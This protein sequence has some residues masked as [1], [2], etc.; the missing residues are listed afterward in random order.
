VAETPK[1]NQTMIFE[2][3]NFHILTGGPGAGKTTVL[4]ALRRRGF[5]GVDEAARQILREQKAVGG[6]ATHDGDRVKYRD[7]MLSRSI[8][9][10]EAV[11]ERL[12][13]E[14]SAPV[15]FDRGIPELLGYGI[16]E[17]ARTPAHVAEAVARYRY[18]PVVFVFPPW[19]AIYRHD[20]ERKHDFAHAERVF[21]DVG[22]AYAA[23]G[24]R[25]V[26]VPRLPVEARVDHIL[27][28]LPPG[29]G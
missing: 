8:A 13:D 22:R 17:G 21:E 10:Y 26:E 11:P 3:P 18:G 19:R 1:D 5:A 9:A 14:R 2:R 16:A 25:L 27:A 28:R 29:K 7:L 20:E 24:Y 4:E 15:F 6:D 12:A 23:C